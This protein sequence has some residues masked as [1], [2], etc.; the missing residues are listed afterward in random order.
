MQMKFFFKPARNFQRAHVDEEI[1]GDSS[2][3][4][5]NEMQL[6]LDLIYDTKAWPL[7]TRV[8]L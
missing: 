2:G 4:T 1:A 6:I 7:C 3:R 8:F 5:F